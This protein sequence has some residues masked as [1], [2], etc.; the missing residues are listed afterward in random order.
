M[1]IGKALLLGCCVISAGIIVAGYMIARQLPP[2]AYGNLDYE[3]AVTEGILQSDECLA[4]MAP[5]PAS[6]PQGTL[7]IPMTSFSVP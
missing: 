4:E 6:M 1:D 2:S 3:A 5:A 7:S